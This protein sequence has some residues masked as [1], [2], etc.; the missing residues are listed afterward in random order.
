MTETKMENGIDI[1]L[2]KHAF[3][4]VRSESSKAT[5]NTYFVRMEYQQLANTRMADGMMFEYHFLC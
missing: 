1:D 5:L 2:R 3:R 4:S